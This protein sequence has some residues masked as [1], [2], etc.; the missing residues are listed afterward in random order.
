MAKPLPNNCSFAF[1]LISPCDVPTTPRRIT[2][3]LGASNSLTRKLRTNGPEFTTRHFSG[4]VLRTEDRAGQAVAERVRGRFLRKVCGNEWLNASWFQNPGLMRGGRS[5]FW[6]LCP[7]EYCRFHPVGG[8]FANPGFAADLLHPRS[9][10]HLSIP[11]IPRELTSNFSYHSFR[12]WVVGT[13]PS[14]CP[15]LIRLASLISVS[16]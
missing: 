4:V 10:L 16:A 3:K 2:L 15:R 6:P 13:E 14:Y 12:V 5:L 8:R 9:G 11:G 1:R 7:T